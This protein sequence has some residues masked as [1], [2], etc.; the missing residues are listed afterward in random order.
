MCGK[1]TIANAITAS[2]VVCAILLAVVPAFSVG[3]FALYLWCGVSDTLDG[4]LAR[5]WG[6]SNALG[7][8][9]DSVADVVFAFCVAMALIPVL[10]WEPWMVAWI[11]VV[12]VARFVSYT[13]GCWKYHTFAALHTRLNK[14]TGIVLLCMPMLYLLIGMDAIVAIV[15]AVATVSAVEELV[16]TLTSTELDCDITGLWVK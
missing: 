1:S 4:W 10:P 12:A 13:V 6:C 9:F 11:C 8:R 5:R 3:F 7:A 15:C 14:L 16:I 2:R